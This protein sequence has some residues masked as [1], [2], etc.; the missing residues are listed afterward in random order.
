M[1]PNKTWP[2]KLAYHAW[3]LMNVTGRKFC[4][5][6]HF[7][8]KDNNIYNSHYTVALVIVALTH[9][10]TVS[11]PLLS[12][13]YPLVCDVHI[14][15]IYMRVYCVYICMCV[16]VYVHVHVCVP[17]VVYMSGRPL[18]H[19]SIQYSDII[20]RLWEWQLV[21]KDNDCTWQCSIISYIFGT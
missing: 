13:R 9:F 3:F 8:C 5:S 14:W 19:N 2:I 1:I 7:H 10:T 12:C 15:H 20:I 6:V 21:D 4:T 11:L 16:L 17:D 18:I